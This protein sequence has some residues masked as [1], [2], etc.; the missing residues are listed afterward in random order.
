MATPPPPP[1]PRMHLMS[2]MLLPPAMLRAMLRVSGGLPTNHPLRERTAR[3]LAEGNPVAP[4]VAPPSRRHIYINGA[5]MSAP[6]PHIGV[7]VQPKGGVLGGES[8]CS[9]CLRN[10]VDD[11]KCIMLPCGHTYHEPCIMQ[12]VHTKANC[13]MC[14]Y[15]L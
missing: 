1:Q 11:D 14:R 6:P 15:Q 9:V 12:W 4:Y 13:P 2:R 7:P 3:A 8:Q 5:E 10:Y